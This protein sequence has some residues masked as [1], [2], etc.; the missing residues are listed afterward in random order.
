MMISS[1]FRRRSSPTGLPRA[2]LNISKACPLFEASLSLK[3][4]LSVG[5][6]LAILAKRTLHF[7]LNFLTNF[8]ARRAWEDDWWAGC[9]TKTMPNCMSSRHLN[10]IRERFKR[11]RKWKLTNSPTKSEPSRRQQG[12]CLEENQSLELR[13]QTKASSPPVLQTNSA[14]QS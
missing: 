3:P 14:L 12:C 1:S 7:N 6:S 9:C 2:M 5:P 10:R 8:N 11:A 13:R 4:Y